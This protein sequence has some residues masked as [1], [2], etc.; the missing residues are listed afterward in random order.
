MCDE[1]PVGV[2]KVQSHAVD[3]SR[4]HD[5]C[6]SVCDDYAKLQYVD[7]KITD[8]DKS[9]MKVLSALNDSG[10]QISVIRSDVLGNLHVLYVGKVKFCLLYTSPSPRD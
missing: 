8:C 9:G 7:V 10:A 3:D 6:Q 5:E 1:L 4:V 2:H